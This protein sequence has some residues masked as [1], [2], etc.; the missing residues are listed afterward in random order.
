MSAP[1]R[2]SAVGPLLT[3][4]AL[5]V[6]LS[7]CFSGAAFSLENLCEDVGPLARVVITPPQLTL[8]SGDSVVVSAVE[9]DAKGNSRFFCSQE[10]LRWASADTSIATVSGG[11]L[12]GLVRARNPGTTTIRAEV[13]PR[14]VGIT[15]VTVM[16]R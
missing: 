5:S 13:T 10:E 7:A 6:S 11:P 14:Y 9:L 2:R 8:R 1:H 15:T 12:V 16:P 4:L 3:A